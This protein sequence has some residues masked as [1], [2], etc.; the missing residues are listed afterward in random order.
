MRRLLKAYFYAL[1]G[2]SPHSSTNWFWRVPD[3]LIHFSSYVGHLALGEVAAEVIFIARVVISEGFFPL[4]KTFSAVKIT[5]QAQMIQRKQNLLEA[6]DTF[7]MP[8]SAVQEFKSTSWE[9]KQEWTENKAVVIFSTIE[10]S[11]IYSISRKHGRNKQFFLTRGTKF[12]QVYQTCFI[13]SLYTWTCRKG[14]IN[15]SSRW[16]I[17]IFC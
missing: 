8:K 11:T 13:R 14:Y 12:P 4:L 9:S 1:I 6:C 5:F 3:V 17:Y 10:E 2:K 15:S 16:T 7:R